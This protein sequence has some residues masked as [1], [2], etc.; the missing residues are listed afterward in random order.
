MLNRRHNS[1]TRVLHVSFSGNMQSN[2]ILNHEFMTVPENP[3]GGWNATWMV[4]KASGM[5]TAMLMYCIHTFLLLFSSTFFIFYLIFCYYFYFI[6]L[7]AKKPNCKNV[8]IIIIKTYIHW[9]VTF[10]IKYWFPVL[11]KTE[12]K[13]YGYL[14]KH[15]KL[16][17]IA[18]FWFH[19]YLDSRS[20]SQFKM[21]H[22]CNSRFVYFN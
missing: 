20:I 9:I 2:I 1:T 8:T 15:L 12:Q 6:H 13:H 16:L 21:K 4:F 5:Q 11:F 10:V 7:V 3:I 22:T 17:F 14:V 18:H 19:V